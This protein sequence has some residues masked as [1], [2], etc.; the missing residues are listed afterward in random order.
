MCY[1]WY[2]SDYHALPPHTVD[3]RQGNAQI[4]Y[5]FPGAESRCRWRH[6]QRLSVSALVGWRTDRQTGRQT[7]VVFST[8]ADRINA[9][10]CREQ[11]GVENASRKVTT[12]LQSS[13]QVRVNTVHHRHAVYRP[14]WFVLAGCDGVA[15]IAALY[16][17]VCL[18]VYVWRHLHCCFWSWVKRQKYHPDWHSNA[19]QLFYT[20]VFLTNRLKWT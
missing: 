5:W 12:V 13:E 7:D 14:T 20:F 16:A 4:N 8:Q 9:R 17:S 19:M 6:R 18:S 3:R 11:A 2:F 1:V 15:Y 10:Q